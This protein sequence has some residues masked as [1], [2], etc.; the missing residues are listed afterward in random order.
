MSAL[1]AEGTTASSHPY[2]ASLLF[3]VMPFKTVTEHHYGDWPTQYFINTSLVYYEKY[4]ENNGR[5]SYGYYGVAKLADGLDDSNNDEY[6][7][8]LDS[9]R[10]DKACV[11]DGYA[12]LSMFYLDRIDYTVYQAVGNNANPTWDVAKAKN[13]DGDKMPIKGTLETVE[14]ESEAGSNKMVNLIQQ[15]PLV[16][17][18]YVEDSVSPYNVNYKGKEIKGNFV[19][20]GM[21]L[22]QLPYELQNTYR[23]DVRNF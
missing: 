12:L 3:K 10:N 9:L 11:E 7:W 22:Y 6:V 19:A 14:T 16:F 15:G 1:A 8:V 18:A 21:Y 2:D 4:K 13:K 17:N 20:N 23:Y 5:Y